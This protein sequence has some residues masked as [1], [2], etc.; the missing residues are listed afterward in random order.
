MSVFQQLVSR[1][2]AVIRAWHGYEGVDESYQ[3]M[4]A[5]LS[6]NSLTALCG[7]ELQKMS[8]KEREDKANFI[9]IALTTAFQIGRN[10]RPRKRR[11]RKRA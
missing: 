5:A 3:R 4:I 10:T 1:G 2:N 9:R 11:C 8:P 6:A 7:D